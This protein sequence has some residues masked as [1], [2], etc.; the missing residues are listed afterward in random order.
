[1]T[2]TKLALAILCLLVASSLILK[3]AYGRGA[4]QEPD[5]SSLS[6]A[7][8]KAMTISLERTACYGTCPGYSLV[9]H[10]DG[11]IE[12]DGRYHVKETGAKEGHLEP[13]AVRALAAEFTKAK[14]WD[15]PDRY[16]QESCRGRMCTD[17]P[18]AITEISV[19]GSTHRVAHYYGCG[20][21]PKPLLALEAAIDKATDSKQWIGDVSKAGPF[22]TTC[23]DKS[24]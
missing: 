19:K 13:N 9:I 12:Y 14:F 22:G 21:A 7:D 4:R 8:L 11:R 6:D 16:S 23:F 20:S 24:K 2:T 5:L 3:F 18:T 1:V 15:I 17:F 10:G